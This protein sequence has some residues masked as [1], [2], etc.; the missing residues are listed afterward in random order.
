MR[1]LHVPLLVGLMVSDSLVGGPAT[2]QVPRRPA[3]LPRPAVEGADHHHEAPNMSPGARPVPV[4][5]DRFG[6][7]PSY[8]PE[9]YDP[10]AQYEIYGGKKAVDRVSP[11]LELGH[12]LYQEGPLGPSYSFLGEKNLVVPQLLV[13]G[14]LRSVAAYNDGGSKEIGQVA[15]RLNLDVDLKLTATERFHALFRPLDGGGEFTRYE[16]AGP[17]RNRREPER[18]RLSRKPSSL[19]FEGDL[20]AIAAGISNDYMSWDLPVT[21]GLIP[22]VFQNG[23]WVDDA[24]RG[25]AFSIPAKNSRLLDISNFDI[26]FFAGKGDVSSAAI[27]NSAGKLDRGAS[28]LGMAVFADTLSGYLEGGYGRTLDNRDGADFSYHNATV[29]LTRRYGGWLSNSMRLIYNWGQSGNASARTADGFVLIS[30]N[31][32]IT[33]LPSTLVPYANFFYGHDRPQSL[34]R[35]AGG[36]LKNIG[37]TFESDPIT[38]SPK[39]DDTANDT[40]GGAIGLQYLFNLDQQ[41]VVEAAT[42]QVLGGNS[43]NDRSAK[44][45]QYALGVRYQLPLSNAW[46]FRMD[47]IWGLLDAAPDVLG[48]RVEFRRKF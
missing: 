36:L 20:G 26:T 6:P 13:Y 28:V 1:L 43:R 11:L 9:D 27:K 24:F 35:D 7:D 17:D 4:V 42:V 21:V 23:I 14:D 22:L 29:A 44:A 46:I 16:F 32:L 31:S 10:K 38:N 25:G 40:F 34:L 48:I 5:R 19:F 47:G 33:S 2:A 41:I 15:T 3:D 18:L 8:P 30:E 45:D 12:P 37:I 39:L